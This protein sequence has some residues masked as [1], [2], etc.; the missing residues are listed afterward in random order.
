MKRTVRTKTAGRRPQ[1]PFAL[2]WIRQGA[3]GLLVLITAAAGCGF[4]EKAGDESR[5]RILIVGIDGA[6]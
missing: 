6:S 1:G 5:P 3:L 2:P 4:A